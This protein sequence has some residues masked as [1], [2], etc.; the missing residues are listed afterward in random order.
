MNAPL[1]FRSAL[2]GVLFFLPIAEARAGQKAAPYWVEP[3][4]QVHARFTGTRGTLAHFGDSITVTMAYWAPLEGEPK[5]MP[6]EMARAHGLVKKF[7]KPEC[8]RKWKGGGFGNT[9][10]M[11]IRW[12]DENVEKWLAKLNPE[13]ALIMFGTN[14]IGQVPLKEYEAK[15]RAVVQRCLKNGTV[16]ILSTIP[17]RSGRLEQSRQYAE[18]ARRVARDLKVP[19]ID[20][21][22][23]IVKRRP[24]DWDGALPK[25]KDV[26]GSEYEVPTLIARD[27]VHPSNPSKFRDYS[28]VSPF[29]CRSPRG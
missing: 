27:G 20:Y 24:D 22:A 1:R 21:F 16:V 23:E 10:S 28:V 15:T 6:P 5:S 3:M 19:L 12:A 9:G 13:V 8:W 17:P 14:D 26:K 29:G 25:F 7:M 11:T 4:K 2:L 18:A